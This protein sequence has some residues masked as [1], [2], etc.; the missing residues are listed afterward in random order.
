VGKRVFGGGYETTSTT[1]SVPGVLVVSSSPTSVSSW[2][3]T[4]R[5]SQDGTATF[6]WRIYAV[7]ATA[8]N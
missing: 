4:L 1:G 8:T 2:S 3:V 6:Q 5:L 7:C